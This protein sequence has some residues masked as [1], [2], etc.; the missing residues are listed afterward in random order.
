[1]KTKQKDKMQTIKNYKDKNPNEWRKVLL[2]IYGDNWINYG[3]KDFDGNHPLKNKLKIS[4]RSL[5]KS[6]SFLLEHQLIR[7]D[8][9]LIYLEPKGFE[10]ARETKKE[11]YHSAQQTS[12]IFLTSVLAITAF[13]DFLNKSYA[14][15]IYIWLYV[16][17]ISLFALGTYIF[18]RRAIK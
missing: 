2:E 4:G 11:I 1:M 18:F 7:I 16:L 5:S 10:V 14:Q 6:V 15:K 17:A 9:N 3:Y 13:F 8:N 12:I